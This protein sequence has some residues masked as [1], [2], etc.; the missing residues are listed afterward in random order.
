M[1]YKRFIPIPLIIAMT[2]LILITLLGIISLFVVP[3]E[4]EYSTI[5]KY[6]LGGFQL[7]AA[8]IMIS[9]WIYAWYKSTRWLMDYY[10]KQ[11]IVI[12]ENVENKD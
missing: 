8:I 6:A 7:V 1:K 5:V 2:W 9:A 10:L 3:L 12:D 11:P 4:T